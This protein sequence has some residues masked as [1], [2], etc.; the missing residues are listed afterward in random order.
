MTKVELKTEEGGLASVERERRDSYKAEYTLEV[1]MPRASESLAD[2]EDVNPALGTLLPGLDSKF[3]TAQVSPWY[4]KL[5]LN[6][7]ERLKKSVARL[8]DILTRHNFYDCETML[9]MKHPGS[10]RRVF[11]MQAEMDVVSDGSDG[12]RLPTM[13]DEIVKSSYYQPFTSYGWKKQTDTPNP[14]GSSSL[15]YSSDCSMT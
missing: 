13:P 7:A 6:K 15:A 14:I 4:R 2:L 12:D 5:Y 3:G 10:G 11:L 1:K 9:N 8:D